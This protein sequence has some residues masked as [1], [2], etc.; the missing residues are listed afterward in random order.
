MAI[1]WSY[2]LGLG[3]NPWGRRI[4][5]LEGLGIKLGFLEILKMIGLPILPITLVFKSNLT[6]CT[7]N[8][9]VPTNPLVVLV[10][11][12]SLNLIA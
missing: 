9:L 12:L 10:K 11:P 6:D 1:G 4:G 3:G 7:T 2:T 8:Q 5:G